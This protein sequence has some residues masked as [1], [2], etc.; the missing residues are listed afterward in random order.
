MVYEGNE[1]NPIHELEVNYSQTVGQVK[2][3]IAENIGVPADQQ[4]LIY[5]GTKWID[6]NQP[7]SD[8]EFDQYH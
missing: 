5:K 6:N 2:E 1:N 8:C 4:L 7:F 3:S